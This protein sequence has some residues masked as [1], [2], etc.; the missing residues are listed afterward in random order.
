MEPT[1]SG[2]FCETEDVAP[3]E[4]CGTFLFF[5]GGV[6]KEDTWWDFFEGLS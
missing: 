4:T 2:D 6:L 5:F 3:P 1:F